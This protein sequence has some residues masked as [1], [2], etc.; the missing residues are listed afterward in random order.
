MRSGIGV[1]EGGLRGI[2]IGTVG[3]VPTGIEMIDFLE[4]LVSDFSKISYNDYSDT[5]PA[6]CHFAAKRKRWVS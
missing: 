5:H 4:Y 1:H 6:I 2:P 3:I